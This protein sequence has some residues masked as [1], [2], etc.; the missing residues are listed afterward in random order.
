MLTIK[1]MAVK[2]LVSWKITKTR[3]EYKIGKSLETS[4]DIYSIT[5]SC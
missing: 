2:E 5:I 3:L 4:E 1:N